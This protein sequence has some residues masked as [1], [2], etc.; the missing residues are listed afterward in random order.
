MTQ[1]AVAQNEH[2][3]ILIVDLDGTVKQELGIPQGGEFDY[4][5][6]NGYNDFDIISGPVFAHFSAPPHPLHDVCYVR[7]RAHADRVLIG[8]CNP[9][10]WPIWGC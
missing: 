5:E 7:L 3:R 10:L 1:I 8:A 2:A 6:A 9:M 4:D